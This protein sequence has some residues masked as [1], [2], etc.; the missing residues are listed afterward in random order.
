MLSTPETGSPRPD[1]I[2][3]ILDHPEFGSTRTRAD[4]MF[5]LA[6]N[7]GQTL[8]VFYRK[9]G[10]MRAQRQVDVPWQGWAR[11]ADVVMLPKDPAVTSVPVGKPALG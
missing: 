5:D 2:V 10:L 11:A 4:G 6:V 7:G 9:Q 1:V 3:S 8:T